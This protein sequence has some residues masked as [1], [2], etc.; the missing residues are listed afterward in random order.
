MIA[1][2]AIFILTSL[3][4]FAAK[5]GSIQI[6]VND[7]ETRRLE[8]NY[9]LPKRLPKDSHL[10]FINSSTFDY[11]KLKILITEL[12]KQGPI[13]LETVLEA[14]PIPFRLNQTFVY[15]S[16]STQGASPLSPRA[17]LFNSDASFVLA[18]NGQPNQPGFDRMEIMDFDSRKRSL[19][20]REVVFERG[21]AVF[22]ESPTSCRK[23]HGQPAKPIWD[24]YA[25]WPGVYGSVDDKLIGKERENYIQFLEVRE[26]HP[27]YR[28]LP[29][30]KPDFSNDLSKANPRKKRKYRKLLER[31][32]IAEKAFS[33]FPYNRSVYY[34]KVLRPNFRLTNA[35]HKVNHLQLERLVEENLL[36]RERLVEEYGELFS[37]L[38]R[39]YISLSCA[40][41]LEPLLKKSMDKF[42]QQLVRSASHREKRLDF[43]PYDILQKNQYNPNFSAHTPG[44][45]PPSPI[46]PGSIAVSMSSF[47]N[48]DAHLFKSRLE[49]KKED[50][51]KYLVTSLMLTQLGLHE[52][53]LSLALE[54][55]GLSYVTGNLARYVS[56]MHS[57][58]SKY[59]SGR[60]MA[61]KKEYGCKQLKKKVKQDML[62]LQA[63]N[64]P[65][66]ADFDE[67][68]EIIQTLTACTKCH[69]GD[70]DSIPFIPFDDL[71]KL[72]YLFQNKKYA[73]PNLLDKIEFRLKTNSYLQMPRG[74]ILSPEERENIFEFIQS[75]KKIVIS[76]SGS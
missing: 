37:V 61:Y 51:K 67:R 36:G 11:Q 13:Y 19:H 54:V 48:Y 7:T 55:N 44:T 66:L 35:L 57:K 22:N 72:K 21:S 25:L 76:Q 28:H 53:A 5:A 65:T 31:K 27:R 52:N 47:E 56:L 46:H 16:R 38:T 26:S 70:V 50:V 30:I 8:Y 9:D 2:T 73:G 4:V 12:K 62:T 1:N 32:R 43:V 23:C 42:I 6:G 69:A 71:T 40:I 74:L 15:E 63:K 49:F 33:W 24:S 45:L 68:P 39:D 75:I 58:L 3:L 34:S 17:I 59:V 18:F 20:F 41:D 14:L 64:F 60:A 29:L 10:T